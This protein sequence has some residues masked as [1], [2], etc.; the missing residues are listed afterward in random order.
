MAE[1]ARLG[2]QDALWLEMDRP[3]NLMVVDSV[4][5]TAEPLDR[6]GPRRRHRAADRALPG[7]RSRAVKDDDGAWCWEPFADWAISTT[8]FG[9]STLKK[10][11]DPRSLWAVVAAHRTEMLDRDL[12]LWQAIWIRRYRVQCHDPGTHH[13]IADGMRMVQLAMSPVRC[14]RRRRILV[15]A[16]HA[17]RRAAARARPAAGPAGP[18]R[19]RG[20]FADTARAAVV[21]CPECCSAGE[22]RPAGVAQPGGRRAHRGR[23]RVADPAPD[24]AASVRGVLPGGGR[25]RRRVLGHP[26]DVDTVRKLLLGTRNDATIW[27]NR[28]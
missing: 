28:R 16:R 25:A 8:T 13:A 9:S 11:S 17:A 2:V 12:P 3:N 14:I 6:Q 7:L 22:I 10:P 23:R 19:G 26:G 4:A 15:P 5:W 1:L 24:V 21:T 18:C 20:E 27:K